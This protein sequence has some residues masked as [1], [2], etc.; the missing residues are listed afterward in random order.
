MGLGGLLAVP[1]G[2]A[3]EKAAEA[4][5]KVAE[6]VDPI[7]E[8]AA[9]VETPNFGQVADEFILTRS[10]TLRSTKSKERLE[11]I[12]GPE[13]HLESLRPILVDAVETDDVLTALKPLC[14]QVTTPPS[15]GGTSITCSR[16][17]SGWRGGI[18]R[19]CRSRTF[20]AS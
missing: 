6:G 9:R 16:R 19:R 8:K 12:L 20:Q 10:A 4:R 13:G 2:R 5:V 14:A 17:G 18:T 7:A 3:R 1:L 11:R 15:G